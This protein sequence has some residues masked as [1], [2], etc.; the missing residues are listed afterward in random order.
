MVKDAEISN[1]RINLAAADAI[2]NSDAVQKE[3]L[4]RA[5]KIARQASA[6]GAVFT[7]D[8]RPGKHRAHAMVKTTDRYS[9]SVNAQNNTLVKS[10]D[11]ARG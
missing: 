10:M 8:V 7:A 4:A 6:S 5:Q 1:L 11:A 2:R 9:Q 3:L